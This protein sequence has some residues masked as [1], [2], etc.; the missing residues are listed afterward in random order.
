MPSQTTAGVTVTPLRDAGLLPLPPSATKVDFDAKVE[1][2]DLGNMSAEQWTVLHEALWTHL[3]LVIPGQGHLTGPQQLELTRKFDPAAWQYGHGSD[4]E[5]MRKSVL[6]NDLTPLPSAPEVKL[7]GNGPV[8]EHDGLTDLTLK[9]PQHFNCHRDPLPEGDFTSTR[10]Y[11]WHIDAALY[12]K[13]PPRVTTLLAL[14]VPE[15][16]PQT[17]RYDDG[18]GDTLVAPLATTAFVSGEYAF[19]QLSPEAKAFA[20]RARV[21]Y[22]PHPYLWMKNAG[23]LPTG[24]GLHSDGKELK[25]DQLPPCASCLRSGGTL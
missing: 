17:I 22:H 11:R 6:Q 15:G 13:H 19:S 21:R 24:L 3:V 10:F 12:A 9:H 18:F 20:L 2:I 16:A 5:T 8:E 1:G 23:A 7:L 14:A 4:I 25:D